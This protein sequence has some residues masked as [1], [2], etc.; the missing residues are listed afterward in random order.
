MKRLFVI[1]ALVALFAFGDIAGPSDMS[2]FGSY[3]L[4]LA[5]FA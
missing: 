5:A 3:H 4:D 2:I 1:C